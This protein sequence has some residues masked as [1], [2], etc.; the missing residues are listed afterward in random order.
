MNIKVIGIA[1]AVFGLFALAA[2]DSDADVASYNLSKDADNFKI[3]RRVVLFDSISNTYLQEVDGFCALGNNDPPGKTSVIC[4]TDK[5]L[6]KHIW[7]T[8]DNVTVFAQQLV[9]AQVSTSFY[10]VIFKPSVIIPD[11][12]IR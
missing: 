11:I 10:K 2:C 5:G 3:L 4:K 8:G 6:A 7:K 12:E 9:D 1:T